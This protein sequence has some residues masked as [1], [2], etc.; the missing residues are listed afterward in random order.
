MYALSSLKKK[1]PWPEFSKLKNK[2]GMIYSVSEYCSDIFNSVGAGM[3]HL[4]IVQIRHVFT[5]GFLGR[6]SNGIKF[7]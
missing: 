7:S 1:K 2:I 4:W 3:M 5:E 6:K